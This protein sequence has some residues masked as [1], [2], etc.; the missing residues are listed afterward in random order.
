[1]MQVQRWVVV[2]LGVM[3]TGTQALAKYVDYEVQGKTY[4]GYVLK[5]S[6]TAPLVMLVHDWDGL[7]EYEVKRADMLAK[8]GYSVF[9]LDLF[10][11]GVRPTKVEDKKRLT[12]ALYQDRPLMRALLQAGLDQA[13]KQGT[14][15]ENA[16]IGGYC[17]GGSAVLEMARAGTPLKGFVSFHGG[18][19]TPA[20]QSYQQA[21][22]QYLILHGT[23]DQL[24]SL[25]EFAALAREL[26]SAKLPNEMI[27]Y[28]GADHAFTVFGGERYDKDA[29][30][31]SWR[32]FTQFL[33]SVM[34]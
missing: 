2:W 10:G 1:M 5:K 31:K 27:A 19:A 25:S 17:F 9:L 14:N 21:K 28:G 33:Q 11:K 4:Q 22:G 6:A 23:A 20:G 18:L 15:V 7:T 8:L 26:E 24:V 12:G 13:K 29:D 34:G 32:T 16:V 30:M 3:L